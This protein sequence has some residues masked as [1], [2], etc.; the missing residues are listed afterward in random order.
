MRRSPGTVRVKAGSYD[1]AVEETIG[2]AAECLPVTP[3]HTMDPANSNPTAA[4]R[5][6]HGARGPRECFFLKD[7]FTVAPFF[8]PST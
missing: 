2:A 7:A 6:I 5:A 3:A 1:A 8:K 4:S